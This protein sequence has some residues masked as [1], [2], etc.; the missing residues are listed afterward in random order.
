MTLLWQYPRL[1]CDLTAPTSRCRVRP[2]REKPTV[3]RTLL[4]LLCVSITCR[5]V[6][7]PNRTLLLRSCSGE[8]LRREYHPNL[9]EKCPRM[10]RLPLRPRLR[11]RVL[12]SE[13]S[14]RISMRDSPR[15]RPRVDLCWVVLPGILQTLV[16]L[17]AVCLTF[18]LLMRQGNSLL[19][20]PS[21]P[22]FQRAIF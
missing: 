4:L 9:W 3:V 2:A 17:P 16:G 18:S 13:L 8:S 22:E 12:S 19:P 11:F 20:P 5:S 14:L 7:S 6:W 21:L 1:F 10:R 15:N